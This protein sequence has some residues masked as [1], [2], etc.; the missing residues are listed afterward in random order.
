MAEFLGFWE[1]FWGDC[2]HGRACVIADC[3]VAMLGASATMQG[4][5]VHL[6]LQ[7][8]PWLPRTAAW[9]ATLDPTSAWDAGTMGTVAALANTAS[10]LGGMLLTEF[11]GTTYLLSW[12]ICVLQKPHAARPRSDGGSVKSVLVEVALH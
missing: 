9:A 11:A 10:L 6:C 2:L 5:R 3:A 1:R 8:L 12:T 7:L 4:D